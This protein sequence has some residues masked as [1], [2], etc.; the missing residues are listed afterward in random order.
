MAVTDSSDS[1]GGPRRNALGGKGPRFL[2]SDQEMRV[3]V[4]QAHGGSLRGS[5][6]FV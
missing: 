4:K 1:H 5:L 3:Q 2:P 6:F